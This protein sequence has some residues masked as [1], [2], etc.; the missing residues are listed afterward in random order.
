RELATPNVDHD[1]ITD[2]DVGFEVGERDAPIEHRGQV[3]AR[4]GAHG[5][6]P[7]PNLLA[8]TRG[9]A[10]L[11]EQRPQPSRDALLPF[12]EEGLA[13]GEVPLVPADDPSETGLQG[14][15]PRLELVAVQWQ[16]HL[17]PQ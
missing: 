9:P 4:H 15:L 10:P 8:R 11:T 16:A 13:S 5:P 17:Q 7:H 1:R 2:L 6:L 3:A 14:C 12:G